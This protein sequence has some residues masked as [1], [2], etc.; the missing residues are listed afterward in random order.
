MWKP[1]NLSVRSSLHC[2]V[3]G[4]CSWHAGATDGRWLPQLVPICILK[5]GFATGMPVHI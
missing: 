2:A 5:Y 1:G 3:G 4:C